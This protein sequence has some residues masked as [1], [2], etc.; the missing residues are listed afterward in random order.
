MTNGLFSRVT[1]D[2]SDTDVL[3]TGGSNGIGLGIARAYA[4][5][6]ANVTIT[7]TKPAPGDYASDLTGLTYTQLQARDRD[8]IREVAGSFSKLDILINNAGASMPGGD[9]WSEEGFDAALDINLHASFHLATGCLESLKASD[10]PGGASVIGISSM[11]SFFG[12]GMIPGYGA[13]KAGVVQLAK[14]LGVAWAEHGI[15][16]NS[17]AAGVTESNMTA[18]M[19]DHDEMLRPTLD[20]TP[21]N[22]VG[23]PE[24]VAGA[25]LFLSSP[26]ASHITG[27]TLAVDGG[28]T[29]MM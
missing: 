20:R 25:V 23:K 27:Q 2:Y 10:F 3:V 5:A 22:R 17:V 13:A 12:F 7:G 18:I 21:L 14:T 19:I 6:G 8:N 29:I 28:F 1:F 16:A 4:A 15:R 24:D 11:T 9:A 26:A